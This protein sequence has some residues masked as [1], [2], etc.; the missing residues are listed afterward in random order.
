MSEPAP[1]IVRLAQDG[2]LRFP[3]FVDGVEHVHQLAALCEHLGNALGAVGV[4]NPTFVEPI[5]PDTDP[6]ASAGVRHVRG[7]GHYTEGS[8]VAMQRL[9]GWVGDE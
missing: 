5:G 4:L 9:Y 3:A 2:P 1:S 8:I 6:T 7:R